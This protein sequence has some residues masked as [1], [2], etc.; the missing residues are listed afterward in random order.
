MNATS[1][2]VNCAAPSDDTSP[3]DTPP[4][5]IL[6]P[7]SFLLHAQDEAG[8]PQAVGQLQV[9]SSASTKQDT[10]QTLGRTAAIPFSKQFLAPCLLSERLM[11]SPHIASLAAQQDE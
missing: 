2:Y 4:A 7:A 1:R 11:R 10:Y 6:V 3:A 5:V 9:A 8:L